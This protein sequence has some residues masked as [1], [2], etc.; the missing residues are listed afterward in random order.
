M[1]TLKIFK[2]NTSRL[3]STGF[4]PCS[5]ARKCNPPGNIHSMFVYCNVPRFRDSCAL[6]SR[7]TLE[8]ENTSWNIYSSRCLTIQTGQTSY[9]GSSWRYI[10]SCERTLVWLVNNSGS[11][12]LPLH[13]NSC[14]SMGL[15]KIRHGSDSVKESLT[16]S[17]IT[18]S[19]ITTKVAET[20]SSRGTPANWQT[21]AWNCYSQHNSLGACGKLFR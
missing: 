8:V 7:I 19:W 14:S 17:A 20:R 4:I 11:R 6:S 12:D 15:L 10:V 16:P 18:R 9:W 1:F 3:Q 13:E 21:S 5:A 2:T